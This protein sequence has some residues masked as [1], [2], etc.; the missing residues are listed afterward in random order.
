MEEKMYVVDFV[1]DHMVIQSWAVATNEDAAIDACLGT[2]AA[3]CGQW[4]ND[5]LDIQVKREERI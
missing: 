3:E 1:Y 5:Y 2:I 4:A